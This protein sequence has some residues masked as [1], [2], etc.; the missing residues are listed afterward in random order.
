M[1]MYEISCI[2]FL[3]PPPLGVAR[4]RL[5]AD[6]LMNRERREYGGYNFK[7]EKHTNSIHLYEQ[8]LQAREA[9]FEMIRRSKADQ[10]VRGFSR[11]ELSVSRLYFFQQ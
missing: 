4:H 5:K 9:R 1:R 3:P 8:Q 11:Y 6:P 2:T 7:T 10:D